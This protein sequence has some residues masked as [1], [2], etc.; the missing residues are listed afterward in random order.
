MACPLWTCGIKSSKWYIFQR[1]VT[2]HGATYRE[3]SV[4]NI[5]KD[6]RNQNV[7]RRKNMSGQSCLEEIDRHCALLQIFDNRSAVIKMIVR[8]W[9][10]MMKHVSRTHR[11]ALDWLLDRISLD[12]IQVRCFNTR[13][14]L[15]DIP[16]KGSFS[17]D[18][19]NQNFFICRTLWTFLCSLAC[20]SSFRID[21]RKVM[22][23]RQMQDIGKRRRDHAWNYSI[24]T[25]AEIGRF[26]ALSCSSPKEIS[27]SISVHVQLSL[28]RLV[29]SCSSSNQLSTVIFVAL[30]SNTEFLRQSQDA[31]RDETEHMSST[32]RLDSKPFGRALALKH[33]AGSTADYVFKEKT[34]RNERM[35]TI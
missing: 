20:N 7:S 31:P 32:G 34:I 25:C 30:V 24:S 2:G 21:D 3:K 28:G 9:G 11:V 18:K 1:K 15:A 14:Q 33:I 8:G 27:S 6:E 5:P 12:P 17:R 23:M 4:R 22:S 13:G 26:S 35:S 10:S 16:T 19:W 29:A